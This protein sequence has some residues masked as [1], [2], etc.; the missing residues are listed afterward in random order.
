MNL[1]QDTI[2]SREV[3]HEWSQKVYWEIFVLSGRFALETKTAPQKSIKKVEA[4]I[5]KQ[6]HSALGVIGPVVLVW[7][8]LLTSCSLELFL[9]SGIL[10]M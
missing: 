7:V 4:V 9:N 3:I 2:N 10:Y 8:F 1:Q 5:E 6:E